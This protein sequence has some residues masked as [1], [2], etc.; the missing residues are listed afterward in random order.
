[1][2][3]MEE[4]RENSWIVEK[5][6]NIVYNKYL[7]YSDRLEQESQA[8]FLEIKENLYRFVA[9]RDLKPG[10]VLWTNRLY[11]YVTYTYCTTTNGPASV[12]P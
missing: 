4:D 5:K 1:M 3:P 9:L 8:I 12:R 7:P 2:E 11:V 6:R 10:V